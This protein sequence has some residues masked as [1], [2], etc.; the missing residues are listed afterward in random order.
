MIKLLQSIVQFITNIVSFITHTIESMLNLLA[1]I[2]RFT[3]YVFN[4]VNGLI[5]D[6]LK[7]FIIVSIIISI[8]LL[9]LGRQK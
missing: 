3:A 9:L 2:P 5:P 1:A 7:P 6:I 4:L 8:I